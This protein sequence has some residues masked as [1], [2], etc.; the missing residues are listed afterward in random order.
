MSNDD[1][2]SVE[3]LLKSITKRKT[4]VEKNPVSWLKMQW[5][6]YDKKE[7][8][9]ILFKESLSED[10][11]FYKLN[12]KSYKKGRPA[13]LANVPQEKL[14]RGPRSV[15]E[16]KKK[17]MADLLPFIPPVYH[18]YFKSLQTSD[19]AVDIGPLDSDINLDDE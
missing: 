17:D 19:D 9:T 10:M 7:P 18:D 2:L 1:F 4:D 8:F 15:T 16:E 5:I 12:F 13:S 6:R 3:N 14:Y 11:E